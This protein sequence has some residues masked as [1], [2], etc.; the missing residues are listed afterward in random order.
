M[1]PESR[2]LSAGQTFSCRERPRRLSLR[3]TFRIDDTWPTDQANLSEGLITVLRCQPPSSNMG[4]QK[5]RRLAHLQGPNRDPGGA[6]F[7][8]LLT[9]GCFLNVS[10]TTFSFSIAL[11]GVKCTVQNLDTSAGSQPPT[12]SGS[13]RK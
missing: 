7:K 5:M 10:S 1:L 13:C 9:F 11:L 6:K 12:T 4:A 8:A 2:T 3:V